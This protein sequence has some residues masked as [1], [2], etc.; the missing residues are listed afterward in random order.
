M[1]MKTDYQ[2]IDVCQVFWP[3]RPVIA[4]L[5]KEYTNPRDVAIQVYNKTDISPDSYDRKLFI[6]K[7]LEEFGY[8]EG[9]YGEKIFNS[10]N[11]ILKSTGGGKELRA[12]DPTQGIWLVSGKKAGTKEGEDNLYDPNTVFHNIL[13]ELE[14]TA[15]KSIQVIAELRKLLLPV[16]SRPSSKDAALLSA[17]TVQKEIIDETNKEISSVTAVVRN[18]LGKSRNVVENAWARLCVTEETAW[19]SEMRWIICDGGVIDLEKVRNCPDLSI[20]L[21][22]VPYSPEHM[23]TQKCEAPIKYLG[24]DYV[25][26]EADEYIAEESAFISG[27]SSTI[28]DKEIREF[29]QARFGVALFGTPGSFGKAMVWQF[30]ASDTAKSSIQEVIAGERGIFSKYSWTGNASVLC[31][32][33]GAAS[34]D[35]EA[36]RFKAN[37]R[38]KRFVLFNELDDGM[39]LSQSKVKSFTGGDS[40][41]GDKKYGGEVNY[42]FT[43]SIFL[44]SNH[45]PRLPEGDTALSSRILVVPFEHHYWVKEK[46]Q[47]NW[48]NDPANRANPHWV[49][50]ILASPFERSMILLWVLEGAR[51]YFNRDIGQT[52]PKQI[53]DAGDTFKDNADIVSLTVRTMVG[54]N[55]SADGVNQVYKVYTDEQWNALGHGDQDGVLV[56]DVVAAFDCTRMELGLTDE[57][58]T[59]SLRR[60]TKSASNYLEET[61]NVRRKSVNMPNGTTRQVYTRLRPAYSTPEAV[62]DAIERSNNMSHWYG[63]NIL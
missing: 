61:Y 60:I 3:N 40:V 63:E 21:C 7:L 44:A 38:G 20:Y 5:L 23:S 6:I 32:S 51:N 27:V 41:Y 16:T 49:E 56:K 1:Q 26:D 25:Y 39:K 31:S 19:D 47:V 12:Y 53:R 11:H 57:W 8:N 17:W 54:D 34:S 30:G 55:S 62:S 24:V 10:Y 18:L 42:S 45:G 35:T 14:Q 4:E 15:S 36:N 29:L 37:A 13:K 9:H 2:E 48:E 59:K 28:P 50:D 52:I 43:A 58:I 46:N 22:V 33:S